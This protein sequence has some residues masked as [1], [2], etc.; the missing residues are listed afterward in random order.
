MGSCS[1]DDGYD[2]S[3][4]IQVLENPRLNDVAYFTIV[5]LGSSF[6]AI[7]TMILPTLP[8]DQA[9]TNTPF[10]LTG[11]GRTTI[12]SHSEPLLEGF[13]VGHHRTAT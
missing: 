4:I 8:H 1:S 9:S 11:K 10:S 6:D 3:Q 7:R 13:T 2:K 12:K 5:T